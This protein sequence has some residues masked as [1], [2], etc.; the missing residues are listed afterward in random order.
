MYLNNIQIESEED[1][2]D[3]ADI[4]EGISFLMSTYTGK[5]PMNRDFGIDQDL[6]DE[7]LTTI[8]TLLSI[9]IKEKIERY[10]SRVEVTDINF[11]Y[12][13]D[14]GALTPIITLALVE[15]EEEEEDEDVYDD[16]DIV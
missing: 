3:L 5:Y 11:D 1:N 12:N 6:L 16:E 15:V 14:T 4:I 9:E 10:D 8:R 7:P 13:S 2:E